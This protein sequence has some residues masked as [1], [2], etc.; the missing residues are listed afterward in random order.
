M[1]SGK[2]RGFHRPLRKAADRTSVTLSSV[3]D[4]PAAGLADW[5][6]AAYHSQ[7]EGNRLGSTAARSPGRVGA[8]LA[9]PDFLGISGLGLEVVVAHPE[10]VAA[11]RAD[12][13]LR[14]SVDPYEAVAVH[15][16]LP[17]VS[18][19]STAREGPARRDDPPRAQSADREPLTAVSP[20]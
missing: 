14:V 11:L 6:S 3:A 9:A 2:A 7:S 17:F 5:R 8:T 19:S 10:R 12:G 16:V 13:L 15:P 18:L 20:V 1:S 4:S